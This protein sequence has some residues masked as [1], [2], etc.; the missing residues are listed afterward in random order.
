MNQ[1]RNILQHNLFSHN[2]PI[3]KD[4]TNSICMN[5]NSDFLKFHCPISSEFCA[6][7]AGWLVT[8][9]DN[10]QDAPVHISSALPVFLLPPLSSDWRPGF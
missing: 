2:G 3:S 7:F 6:N 9:I 10:L 8:D 1:Q 4:S 5:S